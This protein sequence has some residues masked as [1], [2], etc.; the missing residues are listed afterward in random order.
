M[1][2]HPNLL[3]LLPLLLLATQA[4]AIPTP[5]PPPDTVTPDTLVVTTHL[6]NIDATDGL[7]SLREA[8]LHIA[9]TPASYHIRF[10]L[11]ASAP[12]TITLT[13]T[14]PPITHRQVTIDGLNSNSPGD[15]ITLSGNTTYPILH[16]LHST[17]TISNLILAD[18]Y[19][20]G[21]GA[22]ITSHHTSLTLFHCRLQNNTTGQQGGALFA[23]TLPG[24]TTAHLTIQNCLFI[25]NTSVKGGALSLYQIKNAVITNTTFL[26]NQSH[27]AS[28]TD[29]HGGALYIDSSNCLI[30]HSS[31]KHNIVQLREEDHN[32][33]H[34]KSCGAAISVRNSDLQL[35]NTR[36]DSNIANGYLVYGGVLY[37][38]RSNITVTNCAFLSDTSYG[39]GGAIAT[40]GD[41]TSLRICIHNTTFHLNHAP[42]GLG[43][44]I[45]HNSTTPILINNCTFFLNS[46]DMGGALYLNR[47]C[48]TTH[49][50]NCTFVSNMANLPNQGGAIYTRGGQLYLCNNLFSHNLS[51]LVPDDLAIQ[52]LNHAAAYN[53][54]WDTCRGTLTTSIDNLTTTAL[55]SPQIHVNN[56]GAPIPATF[57]I[58]NIQ[59]ILFPPTPTSAA[60]NQ[61]IATGY[62][63]TN[64]H[65]FRYLSGTWID[66]TTNQPTT[67]NP[68]RISTDQIASPRPIEGTAVGAFQ[69][70]PPILSND[71]ATACQQFQWRGNN[72]SQSGDYSDTIHISYLFDS[73][74]NLHLTI[75]NP[76]NNSTTQT[77][78]DAYTWH[79]TDYS[80]T[81]TYTYNY[82]NAYGCP[83]S[84]T[85]HLT[86][87]NST[88]NAYTQIACDSFNWHNTDF[89]TTGTYTYGYTN[90][91]GCPSTDTL[92][93][94]I[95]TSTNNAYTQTACD[96]YNW[97]NIDFT[98][99]GTY[100]YSYTNDNSCPSTDTLHLIINNSTNNAYTQTTCDTYNWHNIDYTTT[101]VYTFNYTNTDNCPST[102]TPNNIYIN[103]QRI[104]TNCL[105]HIQ[106]AQH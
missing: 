46:T 100:T 14:L 65:T 54:I 74:F 80:T 55:G 89:T 81:G 96:T 90:D 85:L 1:P 52:R 86:I 17:L 83:S 44:A 92:H 13:D 16:V 8:L 105:R 50:Q 40:I 103:K 66:N 98:T 56:T 43:G 21:L 4:L 60:Y 2:I 19:R 49:V 62:H 59:H 88:N 31:F 73:I 97:N 99:T 77:A 7:T 20:Q 91:N 12:H 15:T 102:D 41:N 37:T 69:P 33:T 26:R 67:L 29:T 51:N 95:N 48:G 57:T 84:D 22:A 82:T 25:Q 42:V 35:L 93:L 61:G 53:N 47:D 39:H 68:I 72:L 18:A 5:Y 101:G 9:A 106:L 94:T 76:T 3:T 36:C 45:Y 10:N 79:D 58:Q 27:T 64:A 32:F 104:H 34:I 23:N 24:D 63:P 28:G 38:D 30:S 11:P 71:T 87:N 6:D 70:I 78:C 75:Q